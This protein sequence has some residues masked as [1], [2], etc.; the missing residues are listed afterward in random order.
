[1]GH[2]IFFFIDISWRLETLIGLTLQTLIGLV[3]SDNLVFLELQLSFKR[4]LCQ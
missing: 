3:N 4:Q 2:C 1:M